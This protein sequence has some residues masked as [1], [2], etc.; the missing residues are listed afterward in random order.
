MKPLTAF[1]NHASQMLG[2]LMAKLRGWA[3]PLKPCAG[4]WWESEIRGHCDGGTVEGIAQ[5]VNAWSNLAYGLVGLALW[6]ALGTHEALVICLALLVL[7]AGSW[8]YHAL[9]SVKTAKAD[10]FGMYATFGALTA[11]SVM[12]A[13]EPAAIIMAVTGI[14]SGYLF[15]FAFRMNLDAM[16]GL[17][18]W[19]CLLALAPRDGRLLLAASIGTFVL[20][21]LGWRL[22]KHRILTERWGHGAWH[23]LTAVAIGL[24]YLAGA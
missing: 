13:W 9:P 12:P 1:Q 4:D 15:R 24:M 21:Y 22:D 20:A 2:V 6:L 5:P 23:V 3:E 16:M 18:L 8:L 7:T 10:H 19:F 17:F 14:A 11:H